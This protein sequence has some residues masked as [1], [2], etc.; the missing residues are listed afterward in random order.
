[1]NRL[2]IAPLLLLSMPVLAVPPYAATPAEQAMCQARVYSRL[3]PRDQNNMHMHHY[4]DGLRFLD[5]AYASMR[6]KDDMRYNLQ[7]SIGN[8]D[9]VLSHT[10]EDYSMRGE[11]HVGKARALKLLGKRGEAVSEYHKALRYSLESP[12]VYVALADH[13]KETGDKQKALELVTEGLKHNPNAKALK[14]R[15]SELGG[16]L[17]YPEPIQKVEAETAKPET[18]AVE[19]QPKPEAPVTV[20]PTE[21]ASVSVDSTTEPK[22][23]SPKNP[24]CRFCPD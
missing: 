6:D 10:P 17:P 22:I 23:G 19:N 12:D 2:W 9:Y 14:R 5:R 4:C 3:G 11:V 7:R 16:K 24:Y 8:F 21:P 15:Y 20:A 13:Y 18:K 1:M